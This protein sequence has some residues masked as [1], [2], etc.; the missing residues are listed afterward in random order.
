MLEPR[1][2]DP[3]RRPLFRRLAASYSINELGDWMG[4]I[5]LSVLVFDRTDSALATAALFLGTRFLPALF[6]PVLVA[7]AER[8][9]PRFALPVIYCGE[10]AVFGALA[11]LAGHFSLAPVVAL[12]A[13]DGALALAGR[14]LTRAVVA[15]S[16]EPTGE[17]RAGNALLNVA[18]TGGAAVGPA[19][20]GLVV[21]GFG[22]Q[23]ALLLDAVSFYVVAWTL[24]T[25]GAMPQAEPEEGQMRDRVRAGLAYIRG[26]AV[27]AR[28]LSAQ[29]IAFVFF[30]A[31]LPVEVVYVKES[32]GSDDTGYGLMLASWGIGMVFGS[33]IFARIRETSLA[34]QLFFSTLAI[35]VG[36]LGLAASPTLAYACAASIVGGAGNGIQWVATISAVQELTVESMQARVMSVL[37]SI[38]AAMPGVGFAVGGV[39]AALVSP[40]M[41]FLAAGSGVIAIVVV[42]APLLGGKWLEREEASE[43]DWLDGQ[44]EV[45]V[46]LIPP[47]KPGKLSTEEGR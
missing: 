25:A 1:L 37:E 38:G 3:L 42:M 23:S 12:A 4:I 40:R 36:Y 41:T 34:G 14:A 9:P 10:A 21:A 7:H 26:E 29:G 5:A 35:G 24:F 44:E 19:L 13:I 45:V 11:L 32:L 2:T 16:L 39:I 47:G 31:V 43:G 18:F 28:I 15:T 6:A 20:A 46:E 17:L 27:L 30:A 22:V 8:P 33:L